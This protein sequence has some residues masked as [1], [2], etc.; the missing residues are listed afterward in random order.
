MDVPSLA[1]INDGQIVAYVTV[2]SF[3]LLV[4]DSFL[5]MEWEASHSHQK[6][7]RLL[8][9]YEQYEHIWSRKNS[10]GPIKPLYA[11]TRYSTFIT[12]LLALGAHFSWGRNPDTCRAIL[13]ATTVLTG[14]GIGVTEI[15]L[16]IRTHALYGRPQRLLIFFILMWVVIGGLNIWGL[17]RWSQTLAIVEYWPKSVRSADNFYRE[18]ILWY[19]AM[20]SVLVINVALQISARPSLKFLADSPMRVLHALLACRL[21]LHTRVFAA[22]SQVQ[23]YNNEY[24]MQNSSSQRRDAVGTLSKFEARAVPTLELDLDLESSSWSPERLWDVEQS[25]GAQDLP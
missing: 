20:V 17:V 10:P 15:I 23:M 18:G 6:S 9:G 1:T 12:S 24:P 3:A 5:T 2:A 19:L 25:V 7:T 4:Y 13:R 16:F 8:N 22:S 21:V 11:I 14:F